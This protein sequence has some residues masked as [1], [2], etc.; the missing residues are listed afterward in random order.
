MRTLERVMACIL[1]LIGTANAIIINTVVSISCSIARM[2]GADIA[3]SHGRLDPGHS[4]VALVRAHILLIW[5][6]IGGALLLI[7][8]IRF[9]LCCTS[10]Q[11]LSVRNC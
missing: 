8:G 10:G 2:V 5:Q 11:C 3:H 1:G 7:A 4:V 6:R 9:F